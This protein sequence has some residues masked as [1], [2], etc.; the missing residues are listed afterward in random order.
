[1]WHAGYLQTLYELINMSYIECPY[2]KRKAT[3]YLN[4]G[5]GLFILSGNKECPHCLGRIKINLSTYFLTFIFGIPLLLATLYVLSFFLDTHINYFLIAIVFVILGNF[6]FYLL[7]V[8]LA[9]FFQFRLFLPKDDVKEHM[10][11]LPS[12]LK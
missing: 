6:G 9:K 10:D 4:L 8:L 12:Y 2:C 5:N 11:N 3:S 7:I 1:M